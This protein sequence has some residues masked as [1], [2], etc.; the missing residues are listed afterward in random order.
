MKVEE[1]RL[2]Q[3]PV[4]ERVVLN[5]AENVLGLCSLTSDGPEFGGVRLCQVL[6]SCQAPG[7]FMQLP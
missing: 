5:P 6:L 2:Y 4:L 7:T 3:K 1:K